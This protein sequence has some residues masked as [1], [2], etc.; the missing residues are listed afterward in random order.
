MNIFILDQEP[1]K[2]ASRLANKHIGQPKPGGKWGTPKMA[3]EALQMLA[4]AYH[5]WGWPIHHKIRDGGVYSHRAHPYHRCT[6]W[7]GE[8]EMNALWLVNH[9]IAICERFRAITGR[10]PSVRT[11]V[12]ETTDIFRNHASINITSLALPKTFAIADGIHHKDDRLPA[13]LAVKAY[14]QYYLTKEKS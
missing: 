4:N 13:E 12:D 7:T 11:S 2:A 3:V 5:K 6:V 8:S 10:H 1:T 9:A 14:R